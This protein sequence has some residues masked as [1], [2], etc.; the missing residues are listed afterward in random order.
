[1][2]TTAIGLICVLMVMG[3]ASGVNAQRGWAPRQDGA[4]RSDASGGISLPLWLAVG[5]VSSTSTYTSN[6]VKSDL[7]YETT[8]YGLQFELTGRVAKYDLDD[9]KWFAGDVRLAL[10]AV[11]SKGEDAADAFTGGRFMIH[12]TPVARFSVIASGFKISPYL[13]YGFGEAFRIYSEAANGFS[14]FHGPRLGC[15]VM[16][17][18][19]LGF[20]LSYQGTSMEIV[21]VWGYATEIKESI[22]HLSLEVIFGL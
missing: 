17:N 8:G 5:P 6:M 11:R 14:F 21:E 13:G 20:G 9:A 4:T 19:W 12:V 15:D 10:T 18:E 7:E 22:S 3:L 1:M 2:R 16:L